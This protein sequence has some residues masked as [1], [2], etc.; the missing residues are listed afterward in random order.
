VDRVILLDKPEGPTSHDMVD[1]IRSALGTRRVGHTGTLDPMA[2]GLLVLLTGR[3]TKLA[4]LFR[5]H[6][7]LYRGR[8]RFGTSTT[9]DD[10][11]G[12]VLERA[13]SFELDE[14]SLRAALDELSSREEQRAPVFSAVKVE[15]VP[16]YKQARMGL[17]VEAPTRSVKIHRM[18][19]TDLTETE[20]EIEVLCSAGTY[21]RALARDLGK[22]LG[23]PAH[24]SALRR[25][26]SGPYSIDEALDLS[27]IQDSESDALGLSI[28]RALAHLPAARV[29]SGYLP[30]L[31]HGNQPGEEDLELEGPLPA[32]GTWVALRDEKE[33]LLALARV[34]DSPDGP[35]LRLRRSLEGMR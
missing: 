25:L 11:E 29:S 15:G 19:L 28:D 24:L 27:A 10:R 9:T 35:E 7:K 18:E 33:S 13:E 2:T 22:I 34:E 20:V 12:K 31:R 23:L 1:A 26:R 4:E 17:K 8:I 14:S 3:A 6:E 16:L 5:D 30:R 32:A 21:V